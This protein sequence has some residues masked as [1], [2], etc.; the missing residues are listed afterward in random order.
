MEA[1]KANKVY[2]IDD[3]QADE[4]AAAGYDVYD[5]G[6]LVKHAKG[7]TVPIAE[8]EKVVA[9]LERLKK[10]KAPAKRAED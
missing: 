7:K 10:A 6:K 4:Y 2:R 9:E 5:G 8:Y 3:R 1:R